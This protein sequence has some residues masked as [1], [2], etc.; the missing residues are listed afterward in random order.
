[1]IERIVRKIAAWCERKGRM[2]DIHGTD[3]PSDVYL[4]RY[5]LVRSKYFN[6]FI[7]Q[8]LRSDRDDLHDHPW[9]FLTY[10]VAGAY[11]ERKWDPKTSKVM[12]TRRYNHAPPC[13]LYQ[14]DGG[15]FRAQKCDLRVATHRLVFRRA[16]DQHQVLVDQS[17]KI[18]DRDSAPLTICVTGP[19]RREWGFWTESR[20]CSE[21]WGTCGE[22]P[23]V[24]DG[25]RIG[26]CAI[27]SRPGAVIHT[28]TFVPWRKYLGL[29]H[30]TPGRG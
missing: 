22:C 14:Y 8:F 28:R 11:T 4:R 7:H 25:F 19:M 24:K 26:A 2:L 30:D 10:L 20:M 15:R 16:T 1:V 27:C 23:S 21:C 17:L 6:V 29:P 18:E 3:D 5:Y 9:D 12:K 13:W